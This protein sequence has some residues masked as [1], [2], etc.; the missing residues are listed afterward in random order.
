MVQLDPIQV[1]LIARDAASAALKTFNENLRATKNEAAKTGSGFKDLSAAFSKLTVALG[2]AVGLKEVVGWLKEGAEASAEFDQSL[3]SL[4]LQTNF[5]ADALIQRLRTASRGT[6]SD[7]NLVRAANRALTF[8]IPQNQLPQLMEVAAA[9]AKV[10][11]IT[12]TQAFD[13]IVT[14]IARGSPMIL[15]NLGIKGIQGAMDAYAAATGRT[16]D[17]LSDLE[18]QQALTN[19]VLEKSADIIRLQAA[20]GESHADALQRQD[21]EIENLKKSIGSNFTPILQ[22]LKQAGLEIVNVFALAI[23]GV[24][25]IGIATADD[26]KVLA[27]ADA[28]HKS[29]LTFEEFKDKAAGAV[30]LADGTIREFNRQ[31]DDPAIRTYS[32]EL[33]ALEALM[34]DNIKGTDQYIIEQR[35]MNEVLSDGNV[36]LDE[37]HFLISRNLA[38]VNDF[39]DSWVAMQ[40][41]VT[42]KPI[43]ID[44]DTKD[45]ET[46]S[47][48]VAT[49]DDGIKSL[50]GLTD[51]AGARLELLGTILKQAERAGK[52]NVGV[53]Q[54]L[55]GQL[56]FDKV[57]ELQAFLQKNEIFTSGKNGDQINAQGGQRRVD[58]AQEDIRL[59]EDRLKAVEKVGTQVGKEQVIRE[60]ITTAITS[61]KEAEIK[62]TESTTEYFKKVTTEGPAVVSIIK[63]EADDLERGAKAAERKADAAERELE[64]LQAIEALNGR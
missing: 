14:G 8:E 40:E 49:I 30:V 55:A 52:Q 4:E 50:L 43:K 33:L 35:L 41:K 26:K 58:I 11:G 3:Q 15:D 1:E 9:R 16:V 46:A 54:D 38:T 36:T 32:N 25:N 18:K 34:K 5:A 45:L 7:L 61:A 42:G 21:A 59:E 24:K 64:A 60:A 37:A 17:Q 12:V 10:M 57:E 19:M 23:Q 48:A 51:T 6:V 2:V 44:F 62:K 53:N 13:D 20:A 39:G 56:G 22:D 47:E 31:L 29:G 63:Q 28:W 27:L